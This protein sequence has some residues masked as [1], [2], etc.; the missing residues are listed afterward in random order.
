MLVD[1]RR[2][3]SDIAVFTQGAI[4]HTCV[5]P[6]AAADHQRYRDGAAHAD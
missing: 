5:I 3:T 6:I 2:G 1:I 4:R